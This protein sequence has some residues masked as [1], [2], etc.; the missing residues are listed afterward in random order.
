[1]IPLPAHGEYSGR[2]CYNSGGIL[3]RRGPVLA[4]R[5]EGG[6]IATDRNAALRHEDFYGWTQEQAKL[7]RSGEF[8]AL[9]TETVAEEIESM[10]RS[11]R[12]KAAG[13]TGL[14]RFRISREHGT[15][16][17]EPLARSGRDARAPGIADPAR[18]PTPDGA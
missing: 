10:G 3:K 1:M 5:S 6:S 2:D 4:A 18:R 9:D 13:E 7:L 16:G 12:R 14:Q 17:R 15:W 8:S 11:A